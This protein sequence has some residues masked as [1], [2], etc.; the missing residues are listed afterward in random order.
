MNQPLTAVISKE[1]KQRMLLI[2]LIITGAGLWF[3]YDGLFGYPKNNVRAAVYLPLKEKLGADTPELDKAWTEAARER[4]WSDT[5]P[6]KEYSAGDIQIQIGIAI[7]ALLGGAAAA[8]HFLRSLNTTTRLED[9]KIL[10]PDRRVIA[11]DTVR[12]VSKRRWK[13]KGIADLVYEAGPGRLKRFILDDYKYIGADK[14]LEEVEKVL[15]KASDA[16]SQAKGAADA[17]PGEY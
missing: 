2:T 8:T 10:L 5:P 3:L 12:S 9:G 14:I 15:P 16:A 4:G 7:V 6:K 11:I 1:W 13:S 17:A